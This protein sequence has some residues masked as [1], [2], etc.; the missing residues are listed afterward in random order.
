MCDKFIE[1]KKK[2]SLKADVPEL[3]PTFG[4]WQGKHLSCS[5]NLLA[6][7]TAC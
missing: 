5:P 4:Q 3:G 7:E 6:V 2:S 1:F